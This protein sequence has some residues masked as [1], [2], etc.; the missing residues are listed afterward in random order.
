MPKTYLFCSHKNRELAPHYTHQEIKQLIF[1]TAD[2]LG[3]EG[4]DEVF[5]NGFINP[6]AAFEELSR[7]G[8]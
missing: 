4:V 1:S 2:D 6:S 7:R 3:V 5:G 8:Y